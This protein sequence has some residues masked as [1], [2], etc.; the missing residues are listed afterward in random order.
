MASVKKKV[1]NGRTYYYIK[2]HTGRAY[3]EIY[4]GKEIPKN[5]QGMLRDLEIKTQREK[6]K[7]ALTQIKKNYSLFLKSATKAEIKNHQEI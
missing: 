6:W 3:R 7:P 2:H 1:K 5:I 4:L